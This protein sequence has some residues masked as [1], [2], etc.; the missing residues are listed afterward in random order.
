MENTKYTT[1]YNYRDLQKA[2]TIMLCVELNLSTLKNQYC[3][4]HNSSL[5]HENLPKCPIG[6]LQKKDTL[7]LFYNLVITLSSKSFLTVLK[8]IRITLKTKQIGNTITR[9][10][11]QF[12]YKTLKKQFRNDREHN[13]IKLIL[14]R[15]PI[16]LPLSTNY[17]NK[18]TNWY[19]T[20]SRHRHLMQY[21]VDKIKLTLTGTLSDPCCG[22]DDRA[23]YHLYK[24]FPAIS[25]IVL[26]DLYS[27]INTNNQQISRVNLLDPNSTHKLLKNVDWVV[28]S[29]PYI[30]GTGLSKITKNIITNVQKGAI[31]KLPQ[32]AVAPQI[33]EA[34][35]WADYIPNY[36]LTCNAVKYPGF[37]SKQINNEVWMI[38]IHNVK[39]TH[40]THFDEI[41]LYL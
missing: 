36:T 22:P 35:W 34:E 1:T 29:P 26:S 9:D 39:V 11:I 13:K 10:A 12:R 23:T 31:L 20:Q 25:S 3:I 19:S 4:V 37:A 24:M 6:N 32:S 16:C 40:T 14:G 41:S 27:E 33:T 7:T 2:A 15:H 5:W 18:N 8:S 30:K 21:L 38:W 17:S 28:T